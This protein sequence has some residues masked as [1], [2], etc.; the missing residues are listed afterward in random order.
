MTRG[1][2][3]T[4]DLTADVV[5]APVPGYSMGPT[6]G[7]SSEHEAVVACLEDRRRHVVV[8]GH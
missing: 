1:R 3:A 7:R 6:P 5:A 8:M 4:K 2:K